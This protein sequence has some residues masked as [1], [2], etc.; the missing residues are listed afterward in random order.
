MTCE[1]NADLQRKARRASK[2]QFSRFTLMSDF[3]IENVTIKVSY[4]RY[5]IITLSCKIRTLATT[6][7][8]LVTASPLMDISIEN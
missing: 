7:E 4:G 5:Q 6:M 3:E 2:A 8:V 1:V